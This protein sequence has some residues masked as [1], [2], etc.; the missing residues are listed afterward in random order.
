[1]DPR[2]PAEAEPQ[3]PPLI[4]QIPQSPLLLPQQLITCGTQKV[5]VSSDA[6]LSRSAKSHQFVQPCASSGFSGQPGMVYPNFQFPEIH[7][8]T[9]RHYPLIHC[10]HSY[11]NVVFLVL[12]YILLY[13]Y[14]VSKMFSVI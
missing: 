7:Y 3:M 11:F 9:P 13:M 12:L 14:I 10:S 4:Q 1:M 2:N 5:T 8:K 6:F